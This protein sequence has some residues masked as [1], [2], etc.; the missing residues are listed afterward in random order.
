MSPTV[1][2]MASRT[3]GARRLYQWYL[4]NYFRVLVTP[5]QARH[6]VRDF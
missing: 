3:D 2:G 4:W 6:K 5:E 1:E